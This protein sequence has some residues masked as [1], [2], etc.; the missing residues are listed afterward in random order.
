MQR[1]PKV[2]AMDELEDLTQVAGRRISGIGGQI[3]ANLIPPLW[4][5]IPTYSREKLRADL[6][7][8]ATVAVVTIPQAIGFALVAGLPIQAVL[9]TAVVGALVINTRWQSQWCAGMR[10]IW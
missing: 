10:C 7:A 9:A 2:G 4:R 5:E 8:G 1:G 6:L 3:R